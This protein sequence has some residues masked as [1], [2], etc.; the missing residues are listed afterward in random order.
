MIIR[1]RENF[2]LAVDD[3]LGGVFAHTEVGRFGAVWWALACGRGDAPEGVWFESGT[4]RYRRQVDIAP[5]RLGGGW[6]A[7]AAG[8]FA[9]AAVVVSDGGSYPVRLGDRW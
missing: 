7:A 8:V 2:V 5:R 9:T 6:W 4:L 1:S 3:R